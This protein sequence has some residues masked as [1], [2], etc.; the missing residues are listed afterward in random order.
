MITEPWKNYN[1]E[2]SFFYYLFQSKNDYFFGTDIVKGFKNMF[3]VSLFKAI[4]IEE[5]NNLFKI[6]QNYEYLDKFFLLA[7][8]FYY[9][10]VDNMLYDYSLDIWSLGCT[11]FE[12]LTNQFLFKP[13]KI[14]GISK[15]EDHLYRIIEVLGPMSK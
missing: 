8:S 11:V 7:D 2:L 10:D 4:K 3:S 14:S 15:D 12:L 6:I 9:Q 13:K 1:A 5:S